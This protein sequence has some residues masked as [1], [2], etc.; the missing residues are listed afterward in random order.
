E[1]LEPG[2]G[3]GGGLLAAPD[4]EL[5]D[6]H[7][8]G[9]VAAG[10]GRREQGLPVDD[11]DEFGR[12]QVLVAGVAGL[13]QG[14]GAGV[15]GAGVAV[16]VGGV[17]QFPGVDEGVGE[18]AGRFQGGA[19]VREAVDGEA[20]PVDALDDDQQVRVGLGEDAVG[21]PLRG[22]EPVVPVA[23]PPVRVVPDGPAHLVV[24]VGS[25][26]AVVVPVAAGHEQPVVLPLGGGAAR[27]PAF[28]AVHPAAPAGGVGVV[29]EDHRE[30]GG[31]QF[32]H[33]RVVHLQRGPAAQGRV[34]G[35]GVVGDGRGVV[36]H[37]VGERQPDAVDPDLPEARDDLGHGGAVQAER[38]AARVLA[39]VVVGVVVP[40]SRAVPGA[41]GA[42]PVPR[43]EAEA[44]AVGVHDPAAPG[45]ERRGPAGLGVGDGAGRGGGRGGRV[46]V[47]RRGGGGCGQGR[48]EE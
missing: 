20:G 17:A 24:Q 23:E 46:P 2:A 16:E 14:G 21:D 32:T 40:A 39:R 19:P 43:A 12:G 27:V 29:V 11:V 28:V 22:G 3:C 1:V 4:A 45:A 25:H 13:A 38:D 48:D 34:G 30:A 7:G 35:D 44:V 37:L 6:P 42:V 41:A 10:V 47:L 26:H 18:V 31:G 33:H 9:V 8:G 36:D 15:A 5:A